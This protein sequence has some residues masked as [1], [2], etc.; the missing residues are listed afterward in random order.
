MLMKTRIK[1]LKIQ[2]ITTNTKIRNRNTE[3]VTNNSNTLFLKSFQESYK[4][5]FLLFCVHSLYEKPGSKSLE[6]KKKG[7]TIQWHVKTGYLEV[8]TAC[9]FLHVPRLY[10][11]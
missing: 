10:F 3:N 6:K 9:I 7:E 11:C 1:H 2:H 5:F 8:T 4:F